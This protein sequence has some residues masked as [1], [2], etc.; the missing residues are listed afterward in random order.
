MDKRKHKRALYRCSVS[1][2]RKSTPVRFNSFTKDISVSGV[3]IVLDEELPILQDVRLQMD[4]QDDLPPIVCEGVVKWT[5]AHRQEGAS[6]DAPMR[7]Q[8]GFQ[9]SGL[10]DTDRVRL[11]K[12]ISQDA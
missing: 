9:F 3:R 7:Y 11:Q 10:S 1:L 5:L 4:I 6:S 12:I 8:T 2:W